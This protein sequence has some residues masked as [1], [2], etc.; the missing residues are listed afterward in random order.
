MKVLFGIRKYKINVITV[1]YKSNN[2]LVRE[3]QNSIIFP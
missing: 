3:K 1:I 2:Q